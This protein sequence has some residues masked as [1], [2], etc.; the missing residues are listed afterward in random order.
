MLRKVALFLCFASL[1]LFSCL[2]VSCGGSSSSGPRPC[3]GGPYNVVNDWQATVS[4]NGTTDSLDGVITSTGD[5]VF[6]D[7]FADIVTLPGMT[8]ACS[9]S[10]ALTAYASTNPGPPGTATGTASGNFTSATA[11]TGTETTNGI[12]GNVT[13]GSYAPLSG[14]VNV[15][16]TS[17]SALIEGQVATDFVNFLVIGGTS[18]AITYSG[19]DQASGCT[20]GGTFTE[21]GA[22]NVYDVTFNITPTSTCSGTYTGVGF[23]SSSD[24]LGVYTN[25]AT[26]TYLYAIITSSSAPFV[27]EIYPPGG[28]A[29]RETRVRYLETAARGIFG[30]GR[31]RQ[32]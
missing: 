5:G 24:L 19:T 6:F 17:V 9:Y 1:V 27:M 7:S 13:L 25:P 4:A 21:E 14:S 23:E 15:P 32:Q 12:T 22:N 2:I 30:F 26:G 16:T 10:G 8:G 3:T 29:A 31:S 18:S 28:T 20:V 11:F